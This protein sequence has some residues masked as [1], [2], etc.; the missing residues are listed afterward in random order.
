MA[1]V[2]LQHPT[3]TAQALSAQDSVVGPSAA[4]LASGTGARPVPPHPRVSPYCPWCLVWV[5]GNLRCTFSRA[6]NFN[7]VFVFYD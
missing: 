3:V 1:K 6:E 5:S 4:V 7:E 2:T